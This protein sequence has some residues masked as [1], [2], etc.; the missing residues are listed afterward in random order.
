MEHVKPSPGALV[1]DP[2]RGWVPMPP[3]GY[4]VDTGRSFWGRRLRDGDVVLVRPPRPVPLEAAP[5]DEAPAKR[6]RKER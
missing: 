3:D 4:P 2:W 6:P 1:R 5:T